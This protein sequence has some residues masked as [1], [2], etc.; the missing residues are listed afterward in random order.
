MRILGKEGRKTLTMT[1]NEQ[2]PAQTDREAPAGSPWRNALW[3]AGRE[4][5]R[6]WLSYPATAVLAV[7][8]GLFA[9][10]LLNGLSVE[11][12]PNRFA[13]AAADIFFIFGLSSLAINALSK[14]YLYSWGDAFSKRLRFL[15]SLPIS[16]EELVTSRVLAML[17]ALVLNSAAFFTTVYLLSG[18]LGNQLLTRLGFEG[19]LAFAGIWLGYAAFCGGAWMYGE[20]GLHGVTY[21]QIALGVVSVGFALLVFSEWLFNLR[22]VERS[23]YLAESYSLLPA[24]LTL[25]VGGVAFALWSRAAAR[26][27]KRRDLVA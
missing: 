13:S 16:A 15:R 17:V 5:R 24:A 19:Y 4:L 18:P 20:F 7:V 22:V 6:T 8:F 21:N 3:L 2:P 26:K 12:P 27:I 11:T 23:I 25:L 10:A 9:A 14:D 1:T